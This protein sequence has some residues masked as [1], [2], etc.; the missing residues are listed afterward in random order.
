ML[1]CLAAMPD[2]LP[3]LQQSVTSPRALPPSG[4]QSMQ[5]DLFEALLN[6]GQAGPLAGLVGAGYGGMPWVRLLA[7]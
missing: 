4:P 3:L 2:R 7:E 5:Q 1:Q 6:S